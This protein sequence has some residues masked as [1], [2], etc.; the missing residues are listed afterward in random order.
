MKQ[1]M[2]GATELR[3][4]HRLVVGARIANAR[5][6]PGTLGC[7]A[8][9]LDDRRPVLLTSEHVLFGAG[10]REREPV[11]VL[12]GAVRVGS[13]RHGR[14]GLVRHASDDVY[15]DCATA[16]LDREDAGSFAP[17]VPGDP[18]A[19]GDAV[20]K[21]G[22]TTGTTRGRVAHANY[23]ETLS[24]AGR[25][26]HV[27]GQ[28]LVRP[29]DP[30]KPFNIAGDSGAALRGADGKV[31]GLVWGVSA[32]GGALACPIA[33]VLWVLHVQLARATAADER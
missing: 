19:A 20:H 13:T 16:E 31:V 18:V 28:I 8:L 30:A 4:T 26:V 3:A 24:L 33:P 2:Q 25:S 7:F 21:I 14:R 5:G 27:R 11:C 10:G 9:T 1:R 12:D 29:D 15:V 32:Q 17:D 23:S 6:T 22:A